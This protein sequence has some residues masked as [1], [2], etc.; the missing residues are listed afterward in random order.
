MS[1]PNE[2]IGHGGKEN[3]VER[4]NLEI[5]NEKTESLNSH[6][7]SAIAWKRAMSFLQKSDQVAALSDT[8]LAAF[9]ALGT[10][11][12]VAREVCHLTPKD[13][14]PRKS[15]GST[16]GYHRPECETVPQ[17][18]REAAEPDTK[19]QELM[20]RL[21]AFREAKRFEWKYGFVKEIDVIG[22]GGQGVVYRVRCEDEFLGSLA[23]KIMS[24]E[25]YPDTMSYHED[26]KRMRDVAAIVRQNYPS[27]LVCLEHFASHDGI[28]LMFMRLIDGFDLQRL[29]QPKVI[30]N[31]K[32]YV[33]ERRWNDLNDIV[34]TS[35]GER[36]WGLTPGV[37]ANIIEKCLW[38]LQALHEK[39]IIHCDL[40]PSNIMLDTYGA[41]RIIDIGSAFQ[42]KFPPARPS[43]TPRY[44]P[45]EVL[46]K[47][48]WEKQS[49]MA[50]LG[51]VLIE[52]L[53][54]RPELLGP[55]FTATSVHVL[56]SA[57]RADL[58]KLKRKLYDDLYNVIPENARQSR[59]LMKLC[60]ILTRPN[61]KDRFESAEE[62]FELAAS[63]RDEL[64]AAGLSMPWVTVTRRWVTD[65]TKAR[66]V[67]PATTDDPSAHGA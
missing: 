51:Y 52:S 63:F 44:A 32:Q 35:R 47:D 60:E 48:E 22:Q 9:D 42:R 50:S 5:E 25:P 11:E 10:P 30:E 12:Q 17:A 31:L 1:D 61:P 54:G 29:L 26:M 16:F 56:D 20:A 40:K 33:S 38:G 21:I 3:V 34:L 65:V 28:Y 43:F 46:E 49:D 23:V 58:A 27:N 13:A 62:A 67:Q 14:P 18:P 2:T 45:P 24:P 7:Y 37:A 57:T 59:R 55:P 19:R 4:D 36:R 64:A 66:A 39:D 8:E 53:T 41:I 6:I 15:G